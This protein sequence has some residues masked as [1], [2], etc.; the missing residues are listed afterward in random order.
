MVILQPSS[1]LSFAC[2]VVRV[3][4]D[5]RA[6]ESSDDPACE[7][8]VDAESVALESVEVSSDGRVLMDGGG[9]RA[10]RLANDARGGGGG[11]LRRRGSATGNGDDGLDEATDEVGDEATDEVGDEADDVKR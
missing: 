6:L 4:G 7:A 2:R 11:I 5:G 3:L 8:M 9:S 10:G 1:P